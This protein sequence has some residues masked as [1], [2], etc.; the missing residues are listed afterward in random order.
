MVETFRGPGGYTAIPI[1]TATLTLP[2]ATMVPAGSRDPGSGSATI[3]LGSAAN[4]FV[5]GPAGQG[6]NLAAA[7]ASGIGPPGTS[8]TGQNIYPYQPQFADVLGQALQATFPGGAQPI[9]GGPPAYPAPAYVANA[10][11]AL[12]PQVPGGWSELFYLVGLSGPPPTGAYSLCVTASQNGTQSNTCAN[13]T[14]T[15]AQTLPPIPPPQPASTGNGGASIAVVLTPGITEAL[16]N[17]IDTTAAQP[18]PQAA[19]KAGLTFATVR[20]TSSGTVIIPANLG[21]GGTPTFCPGDQLFVQV[22]GFDYPDFELTAP[23]NTAQRPTMPAQ[24]D[25]S[26]SPPGVTQ[27]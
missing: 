14:L 16:V 17:V 7:D 4:S 21:A 5:T 12:A 15:S 1:N 26:I 9:Y 13:A 23:S 11:S 25:I 22:F 10:L 3:P 24:A 19:C 20:V 27:E 6:T 2:S 8:T 18:N